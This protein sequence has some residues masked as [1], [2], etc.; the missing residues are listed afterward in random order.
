MVTSVYLIPT[1][2]DKSDRRADGSGVVVLQYEFTFWGT[3]SPWL[4]GRPARNG[5]DAGKMPACRKKCEHV[6]LQGRGVIG[7]P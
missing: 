6:R 4:R 7:P 5:L 2:S 1:L 3:A